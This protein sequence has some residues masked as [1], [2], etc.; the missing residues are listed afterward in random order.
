[1]K[2]WICFFLGIF[3]LYYCPSLWMLFALL[4]LYVTELRRVKA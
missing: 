2:L 3:V 1:M 4:A